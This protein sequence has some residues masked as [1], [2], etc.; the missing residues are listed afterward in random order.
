M[1]HTRQCATLLTTWADGSHYN[2]SAGRRHMETEAAVG[3]DLLF[4][5][6]DIPY[7]IRMGGWM[8]NQRAQL[9]QQ[10]IDLWRRAI[11]R[12][13][14]PTEASGGQ[15]LHELHWDER[16]WGQLAYRDGD[17]RVG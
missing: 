17:R 12:I 4:P 14:F 16:W 15:V 2:A 1:C 10:G 7:E 13:N 11:P 3:G 8:T 6:C 5:N 9:V